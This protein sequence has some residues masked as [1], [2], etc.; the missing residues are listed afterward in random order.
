M[1]FYKKV[2]YKLLRHQKFV[3]LKMQD[4]LQ[5]ESLEAVEGIIQFIDA[6]Q[7]YATLTIGGASEEEVYGT[8]KQVHC[9][10]CESAWIT[11]IQEDENLIYRCSMCTQHIKDNEPDRVLPE[12]NCLDEFI[13]DSGN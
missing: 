12:M 6:F 7:D 10:I 4:K 1:N 8:P 2:D 13:T 3:L 5:G 11:T 9:D